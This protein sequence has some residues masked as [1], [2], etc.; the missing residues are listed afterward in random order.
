VTATL[1]ILFDHIP[2]FEAYG[3]LIGEPVDKHLKD[4]G[5]LRLKLWKK[6]RSEKAALHS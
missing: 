5:M 3:F 2:G 1:K 4:R 6:I